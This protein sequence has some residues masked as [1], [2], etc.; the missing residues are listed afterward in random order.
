MAFYTGHQESP[1]RIFIII[2]TKPLQTL[3]CV[4]NVSAKQNAQKLISGQLFKIMFF[5][6]VIELLAPYLLSLRFIIFCSHL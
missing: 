1:W 3:P 5:I 4:I 2:E 6:S